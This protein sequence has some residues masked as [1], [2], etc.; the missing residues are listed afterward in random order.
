MTTYL[1]AAEARAEQLWSEM[2]YYLALTKAQITVAVEAATVTVEEREGIRVDLDSDY[3]WGLV[4][5]EAL[6]Y[7]SDDTGIDMAEFDTIA[8]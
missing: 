2:P 5:P 8:Y 7:L 4:L 6:V 3:A 1:T